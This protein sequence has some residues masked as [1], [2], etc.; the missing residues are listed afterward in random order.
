MKLQVR[1]QFADGFFI[2]EIDW[3]LEGILLSTHV[4]HNLQEECDDINTIYIKITPHTNWI[5]KKMDETSI[6][7]VNLRCNFETKSFFR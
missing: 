4:A 1:K 3:T 2:R 7:F 5:T 6:K